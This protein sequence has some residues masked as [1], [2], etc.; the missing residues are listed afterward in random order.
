MP[1]SCHTKLGFFPIAGELLGC[2]GL[3][4]PSAGSDPAAMRTTAVK[5]GD[6]YV[7]NGEKAWITSSPV[8]DLAI[9][10]AKVL[11]HTRVTKT[12]CL[13]ASPHMLST[14]KPCRYASKKGIRRRGPPCGS[15]LHAV[16]PQPAKV[17]TACPMLPASTAAEVGNGSGFSS[18]GHDSEHGHFPMCAGVR[19][20]GQGARLCCGA[21]GV[22]KGLPYPLC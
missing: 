2:F 11:L 17:C 20:R 13:P 3:T 6:S 22:L 12:Q 10:W 16:A 18:I 8:A 15:M 19:R 7:L 1:K 9:I 21:S 5:D 14:S 4:E